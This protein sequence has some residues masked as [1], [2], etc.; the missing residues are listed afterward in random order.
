[1][2]TILLK[3]ILELLKTSFSSITTKL[4]TIKENTSGGVSGGTSYS[5]DEKL[6]GTWIN[7]TNLY[8]RSFLLED[9]GWG[10][11]SWKLDILNTANTGIKI[12]NW[13]GW[14][15]FSSSD[16]T[17]FPL[18]YF[19]NNSYITTY[20]NENND[21]ICFLQKFGLTEHASDIFITIQ[22]TKLETE[23]ENEGV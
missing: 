20:C 3:K 9:T 13:F 7:G 14:C 23:L 22:Y 6:I 4:E 18:S 21:D 11:D 5:T 1:M 10:E 17:L 2:I 12:K 15:R 8:Q 16:D 19:R